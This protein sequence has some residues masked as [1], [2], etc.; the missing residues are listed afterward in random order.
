M[1]SY[2]DTG[3]GRLI[4]DLMAK[5]FSVRRSTKAVNAVFDC[6][7]QA[8]ARGETVEAP[9]G[10]LRTQIRNGKRHWEILKKRRNV[11]T[12][13]IFKTR[14]VAL[15]GR[16][17]VIKFEPDVNLNLDHCAELPPP[18]IPPSAWFWPAESRDPEQAEIWKLAAE[19]LGHPVDT[20]T[21]AVLQ[22]AADVYSRQPGALLNML[23]RRRERGHRPPTVEALAY[24]LAT[25]GF[26]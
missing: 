13:K 5:G 17:R 9:G 21:V 26:R 22:D 24:D 18:S 23:R 2:S 12:G 15:P 1:D 20:A 7:R 16:R 6:M 8:L 4:R 19:L 10:L 14:I 25:M 11:N 3:K